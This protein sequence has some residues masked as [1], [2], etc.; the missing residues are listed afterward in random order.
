MMSL[1][2]GGVC[3]EVVELPPDELAGQ[4]DRRLRALGRRRGLGDGRRDGVPGGARGETAQT[5]R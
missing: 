3:H 5:E 4:A 2:V 1:R